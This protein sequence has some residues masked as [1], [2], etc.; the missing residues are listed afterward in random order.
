VILTVSETRAVGSQPRLSPRYFFLSKA[1]P[2]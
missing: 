1:C 2:D